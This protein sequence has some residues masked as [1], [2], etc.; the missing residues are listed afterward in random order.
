MSKK[1][2]QFKRVYSC[3]SKRAYATWRDARGAALHRIKAAR[4]PIRP[5]KCRFCQWWHIGHKP[6][7]RRERLQKIHQDAG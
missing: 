7:V 5:Y 6:E 4:E 2:F 3:D 1:H